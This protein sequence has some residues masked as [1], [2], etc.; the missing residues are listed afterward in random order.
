MLGIGLEVGA[1][2]RAEARN[3]QVKNVGLK[4]LSNRGT[5]HQGT[6]KSLNLF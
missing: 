4:L 5:G 6:I 3:V 2:E 1:H